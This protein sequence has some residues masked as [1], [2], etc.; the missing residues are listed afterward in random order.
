MDR[1][2]TEEEKFYHGSFE[3]VLRHLC[4][5]I[6]PRRILEWGPG[7]STAI[8]AEECP[9]AYILTIEH[10]QKWVKVWEKEFAGLDQIHLEH[11]IIGGNGE[12]TGYVTYPLLYGLI[13]NPNYDLV[14][15]DGRM[16]ADCLTVAA[17]ISKG[18]SAVTVLHDS[19]REN[20]M[21][22]GRAVFP[23]FR[24]Y[25]QLH[26]AVFAHHTLSELNDFTPIG[27]QETPQCN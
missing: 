20:Y 13:E 7:P 24:N 14:F 17:A 1:E 11:R 19:H 26:T 18:T 6:Q 25:E 3:Q 27:Y 12:S 2:P 23:H 9:E 4:R 5:K 15:V 16:R 10:D 22:A 8:M 21:R